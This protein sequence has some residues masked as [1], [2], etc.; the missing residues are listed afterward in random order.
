[1]GREDGFTLIEMLVAMTMGVIVMGGVLILLIG[2]MR[3]QPKLDQQATDIQT[4]RWV[5][6]RM[7]REIRDGIVVDRATASSVSFQGYVRHVSCGGTSMLSST[8]AAR[9]CEITY[10]CAGESCT[11]IEADPGTYTG[12]ATT[13]LTGLSNTGSVFS[14]SPATEPTYVGVTLKLADSSGS[15]AF[16]ASD[17]ASLRNATL[18]N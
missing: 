3:S 5:L 8:A 1:M 11:R 10:T 18:S 14:Y 16:V 12:T 7:T 6:E 15:G 4:A 2:A 9:K 13:V 17:G